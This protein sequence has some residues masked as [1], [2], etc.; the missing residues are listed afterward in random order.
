MTER[1][2]RELRYLIQ[3]PDGY[4][5]GT[6]YPVLL[7][8]H[9]AGTRGQDIE[10]LRGN[11]FFRITEGMTLPFVI[12]A[13]LC[14]ADSWFD[15][16]EQLIALT[17]QIYASD[18]TDPS[19]FYATGA[20][21]GGYAVWQLAMSCPDLFAAIL[22]ICGGGMYWNAERLK[23]IPVWAFHG[24]DDPVVL[25]RE[26]RAMTDA[27]NRCGGSARLTVYPNCKHDAW[28]QTYSDAAVYEWLLMQKKQDPKAV[29]APLQDPE[30]YG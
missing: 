19:R 15:I 23:S 12:V 20:S 25:V 28:S 24:E 4:Q 2:M 14:H 21:M 26:S 13:P 22:P 7:Y 5:V 16:F 18:I 11:P 9:G 6:R 8:L 29:S 30:I 10:R 1:S 27:V 17:K 3:Y